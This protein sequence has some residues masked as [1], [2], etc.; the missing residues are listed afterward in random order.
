M[1][2]ETFSRQQDEIEAE[3]NKA[4]EAASATRA[5]VLSRAPIL[6]KGIEI[7]PAG[8][9]RHAWALRMGMLDETTR[10]PADLSSGDLFGSI[11][12]L[13]I[14]LGPFDEVRKSVFVPDPALRQHVINYIVFDD[15]A[16]AW[17]KK[18]ELS[19]AD[20]ME[21]LEAVVT[22]QAQ[23]FASDFDILPDLS[24]PGGP[25]GNAPGQS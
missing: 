11:G 16:Q 15:A 5:A 21:G 25:S 20:V 2:A 13:W 7:K 18:L 3:A 24:S 10:E 23:I 4:N 14:Y 12:L 6:W 19:P 1:D 17:A 22:V 8:F 9:E